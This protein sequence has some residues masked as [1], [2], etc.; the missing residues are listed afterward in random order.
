[1]ISS[2]LTASL[3]PASHLTIL[4]S[5]ITKHPGL[6]SLIIPLIPRPTLD[7]AIQALNAAAKKIKDAH[8]YSQPAPSVGF[9]FG[10]GSPQLPPSGLSSFGSAVSSTNSTPS[11]SSAGS[12]SSGIRDGYVQNRLRPVVAEF[13]STAR[14]YLSYFTSESSP[15]PSSSASATAVPL[16]PI[17]EL[18]H[19]ADTFTYLH[20]LTLHILRLS[21]QARGLVVKEHDALLVR[22]QSE[23]R[24][25]L[26]RIDV[27]VNR[28]AGMYGSETVRTWE[29]GLDELVA[30]EA[31]MPPLSTLLA[32]E[33]ENGAEGSR[34]HL[35]IPSLSRSHL[36]SH[37]Q[38]HLRAQPTRSQQQQ[39][40]HHQQQAERPM[41]MLRDTWV[42][43]VGWLISRRAAPPPDQYNMDEDEDI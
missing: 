23:W 19:P 36:H 16:H 25:W 27:H 4:T 37:S 41:R 33:G 39:Q 24:A 5:L 17:A 22:V 26:D 9:G 29:R 8:P 31:E 34:T 13:A 6:K 10:F 20:T 35:S 3:P 1:M 38:N 2:S 7:A 40:Q 42:Q 14:S 30:L 43:K 12:S 18:V 28:S 11:T 32:S 15:T 21:P